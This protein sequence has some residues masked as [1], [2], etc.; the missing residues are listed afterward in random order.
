MSLFEDL[1]SP[2]SIEPVPNVGAGL[3]IPTGYPTIGINGETITL[4]GYHPITGIVGE[5]NV[6]KTQ[7]ALYMF[8]TVLAWYLDF[9]EGLIYDTETN[10]KKQRMTA[11][12]N[13]LYKWLLYSQEEINANPTKLD[14]YDIR[15]VMFTTAKKYLGDEM[16][17]ILKDKL[18]NRKFKKADF[19]TTPFK[20]KGGKP[21]TINDMIFFLM[22]S[23]SMFQVS[24]HEEMKENAIGHKKRNM[25]NMRD[26]AAKSQLL[27]ELPV[28]SARNNL[29]TILTA[30]VGQQHQIDPMQPPKKIL[31]YLSQKQ[32]IKNVP[33]KF[34]FVPQNVFLVYGT[35]PMYMSSSDKTPRYPMYSGKD[36]MANV[37]DLQTTKVMSLRNKSGVSG[38]SFDLITSQS[39]GLLPTLTEFNICVSEGNFGIGTSGNYM[40]MELYPEVKFSRHTLRELIRE[41]V[42]LCSAIRLTSEICQ[43]AQYWL[44]IV[45]PVLADPKDI[46][47]DLIDKGYNWDELLQTR[48]YWVPN[49]YTHP[50]PFLSGVD[51]LNIKAG[52]YK[53]YFI[54]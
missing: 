25:E 22:D 16:W 3:D 28:F 24:S 41:D 18:G 39:E 21:V 54:K 15:K 1:E 43:A 31:A 46:Y 19:H 38:A 9:S 7:L 5:G 50:I 37:T 26:A 40:Y 13:T 32:K 47:Q 10:L 35:S 49:Q 34:L 36:L 12:A 53:P 27:M 14:E 51:L 29:F 20:D 17:N 48:G 52:I 4:G 33:E 30:H 44:Q 45:R 11:I 8:V 6:G 23:I 2:S 42:K